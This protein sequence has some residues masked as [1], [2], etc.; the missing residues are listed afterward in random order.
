MPD[1]SSRPWHEELACGRSRRNGVSRMP[2]GPDGRRCGI[3]VAPLD[4]AVAAARAGVWR[5]A[6][7]AERTVPSCGRRAW[8]RSRGEAVGSTDV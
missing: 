1:R 7:A 2:G 5:S 8:P 3:G 4:V 6:V